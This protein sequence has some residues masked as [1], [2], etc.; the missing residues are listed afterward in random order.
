MPSSKN[1]VRNIPEEEKT[2]K[3]RGDNVANAERDKLRREAIKAGLAK[4]GDGKDLDHIK[5]L[6]T[7]GANTLANARFVTPAANRSFARNPD[8]SLK[9]QISAREK[10]KKGAT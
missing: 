8:G 3:A 9:S 1:Y 7:G 10:G 6:S 4:R 5:P 2:A